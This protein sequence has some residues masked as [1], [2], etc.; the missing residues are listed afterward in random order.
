MSDARE[1]KSVLL[2]LAIDQ[3]WTWER[4]E[5]AVILAMREIE[6]DVEAYACGSYDKGDGAD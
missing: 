1:V 2:E 5:I 6:R 4:L 3:D